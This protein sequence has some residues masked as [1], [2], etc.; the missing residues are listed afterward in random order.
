MSF[1]S[2]DAMKQWIDVPPDGAWLRNVRVP[3]ANLTTPE[4]PGQAEPDG[5]IRLDLRIDSGR[6]AA[7]APPGSGS[8][9]IDLA[10]RQVWPCLVDGHVHLDKT[11]TL[12]RA[13]NPTATH[14]GAAEAVIADMAAHYSEAD[15]E[16]R[17][18]FGLACAYAHGVSLIRTHIDSYGEHART[19]WGVFRRLRDAWAGRIT[20]Q[21]VSI[22]RLNTLDGEAGERIADLVADNGGLLGMTSTGLPIDEDFRARLDRFFGLAEARG[23]DLD[24]HVDETNDPAS[25]ALREVAL[26]A[27]R[28]G[29]K[30]RIQ[31]GHTCSLA[32]QG[33]AAIVETIRLVRDAGITI[34]VLPMCNMFLQDRTAGRTPRWRGVTPVQELRAAG[35]PVSFASDNCRDPF[36]AYGDNDMLEVWREAV[37]ICQLDTPFGDWAGSV[38]SLPAAALGLPGAAS[39]RVG[40]PA[41]LILF[42]ARSM[43]ELLCRPQSDRVVLRAGRAIDTSLPDYGELDPAFS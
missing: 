25:T 5:S 36:Y 40:G 12:P 29:F 30:G 43:N 9:G 7:L 31:C 24:L 41:D 39:I 11:Q 18:A 42:R 37:R 35:V 6:I 32:L 2:P 19:G 1:V 16:A 33:E 8:D 10:G 28:R 22:S 14:K 20:L 21:A 34:I 4:P 15:I 13:P 3:A 17:F 27:L 23:L 26:T 38:A